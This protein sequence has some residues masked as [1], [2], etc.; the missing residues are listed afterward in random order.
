MCEQQTAQVDKLCIHVDKN[1]NDPEDLM[2]R[3]GWGQTLE[4]WVRKR[5][6]FYRDEHDDNLLKAFGVP[7]RHGLLQELQH[8]LQH[9]DAGVE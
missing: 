1:S 8:V 3:S 4:E 2:G 5:T 6:N 9:F 7:T